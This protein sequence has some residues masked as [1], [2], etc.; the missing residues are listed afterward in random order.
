MMLYGIDIGGT[1]IELAAFNE[2][3]ENLFSER[4]PTPKDDYESWLNGIISLIHKADKHFD[5]QGTIGIGIPGFINRQTGLAEIANIPAAHGKP[6][7]RDLEARLGREV[8][9]E[10][11]ANCFAL[12]EA[13][14]DEN[15]EYGM[16]L[17]LIIGTGF[18]GGLIFDGKA[19]AGHTGM[20]GE[21]GHIP[22]TYKAVN[23]LGGD[24]API[25][26]CG[27]GKEGCLD[28]YISGR[29]FEKL[30]LSLNDQLLS[31]KE[32]IANFYAG[33]AT[34]VQFVEK[35]IELAAISIGSLATVLDPD[36]IV[37]GGGLSNFDYLYEALPK[38]M[39]PHM[40]R[41]AKEPIV[42]KA[43]FGDSGGVRGAAALFLAR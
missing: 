16:V 34:A 27:C 40:M 5:A 43:L 28:T 4:I 2:N 30:Y 36:V 42:K 24:K 26:T 32:I 13:W 41:S 22:L 8:R 1:K 6:I 9:I 18:G 33:E 37:F 15:K 23:L 10:N 29:G 31:A 11:D 39:K 21:V 7:K 25:Y 19:Y 12:S 20:A 38:A 3:L 35:Y 17:G 14:A